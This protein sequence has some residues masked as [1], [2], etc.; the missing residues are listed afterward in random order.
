MAIVTTPGA[1]VHATHAATVCR[2]ALDTA[3]LHSDRAAFRYARDGDW[4]AMTYAELGDAVRAIACGLIALGVE[5]G[6]RVSILSG[7]R[8]EWTIADFAGLCAGAVVAPIYHTNSP[9]ECRYVLD[10]A[11]SRV[12]FCE[13][14]EQ[15]AKV[16]AVRAD[17]PA[18]EH[19][20]VLE[21]S[22]DG[23]LTLDELRARGLEIEPDAVDA[24]ARAVAP[25]DTATIVYTSGTTGPP[26]GC[27]TTHDNLMAT[28]RMYEDELEFVSS[29]E[30]IVVFMFLPL[31]HSLARV[32][33]M[34]A[35]DVGATIAFWRGDP[36]LVLEDL[37]A[38]RPTHVP[39]VPRVFEK[40]HTKALAGVEE[41]SRLK[42]A[43]FH[44]ALETGRRVRG[45]E[46]R[47][48]SPSPLLRARHALADRLV[49]SRVRGLFGPDIRLALTG[50]AP[51]AQ[52]VLEFFDACG[53][54]VLEGYGMTE[55][56]AAGTLNTPHSFRFGSV[57]RA[58]PGTEVAI[59]GDGEI[60]MRGPNIFA[61]YFRDDEAT[62]ETMTEDG[63]LR[64]GDL[65]SVDED[66]FV[67]IT[68]RKKDLIITSS[69][70]NVS[71]ANIEAALREIRWVS[72]AVVFGDN[73][74]F[75]VALLTLDPDEAPALAER[76]GVDLDMAAMAHDHRVR[77]ELARELEAV[78]ARFARIEQIKRFAVA[79]RDFSQGEGELTPTLKV[80]RAI[81]YREYA[82]L[83]D[84]LYR[85]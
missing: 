34:V 8:F 46:R 13:N 72:E 70:K 5:P 26:K 81:V 2:M 14:A 75:L 55:T 64:S 31:A 7:T 82:E 27:V 66:G 16:A 12:V 56:T 36:K 40:V 25:G 65:G 44:R 10:H 76:A 73:R 79:E 50:A 77:A 21:G 3:A 62:R 9:E 35:L 15:A 4:T 54:L 74:P 48:G 71:A 37:A 30:P 29:D 47:G 63:W 53:V 78:N 68:G 84:S 18:L 61:G 51:I 20:V 69:G 19:V 17:C 11:G 41:G 58:L 49:L 45:L 60:L 52:D 59:A 6:D 42:R 22:A 67:R 23:A 43:I 33:Q 80:K 83:F 57:G 39:S 24:A 1:G 28:V 32:T 38:T 85:E